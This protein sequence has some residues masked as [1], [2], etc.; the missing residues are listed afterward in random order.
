MLGLE[1]FD[2]FLKNFGC[3]HGKQTLGQ[4]TDRKG[5]N[6]GLDMGS[7]TEFGVPSLEFDSVNSIH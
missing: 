4:G 6:R 2:P 7:F 5:S 3:T 1:E